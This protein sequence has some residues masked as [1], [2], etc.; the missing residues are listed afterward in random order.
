MDAENL[1]LPTNIGYVHVPK[2]GGTFIKKWFKD[3]GITIYNHGHATVEHCREH[4][5]WWFATVRNPYHRMVSWYEFF[6]EKAERELKRNNRPPGRYRDMLEVY[7]KGFKHF[8]THG[9]DAVGYLHR[10]QS[11]WVEGVDCVIKLEELYSQWHNIY[12]RTGCETALPS[13]RAKTKDISSYYD[14]YTR[15]LVQEL[16][17]EDFEQFGYDKDTI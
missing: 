12:I 11:Q 9:D 13:H 10:T 6:K 16:Y 15:T 14:N 4:A 17:S 7:N 1:L 3:N 5:R 2:T 8:L